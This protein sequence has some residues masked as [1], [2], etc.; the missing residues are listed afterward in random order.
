MKATVTLQ[1]HLARI[2]I[3]SGPKVIRTEHTPRNL[4]QQINLLV[5]SLALARGIDFRAAYQELYSR[6]EERY[7]VNPMV[8]SYH[9]SKRCHLDWVAQLPGG[10]RALLRI[11]EEEHKKAVGAPSSTPRP[12]ARTTPCRSNESNLLAQTKSVKLFCEIC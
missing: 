5:R 11:A 4:R 8:A 7:G 6:F 3:D 10:L 2:E 12:Q 9:A 1:P